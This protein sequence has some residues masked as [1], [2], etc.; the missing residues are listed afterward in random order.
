MKIKGASTMTIHQ[1]PEG[2]PM[3]HLVLPSK[4]S[5]VLLTELLS[6]I[7]DDFEV[8]SDG[9]VIC[10][11][12]SLPLVKL[13]PL[14]NKAGISEVR[15]SVPQLKLLERLKH[16]YAKFPPQR[17]RWVVS[18][19]GGK[20]ST[21][22]LMHVL[23]FSHSKGFQFS[24]VHEYTG[25]EIP[26]LSQ[27]TVRTLSWLSKQGV[28]VHILKPPANFFNV[29]LERG[30]G[31]PHW[32]RRWCCRIFKEK[33]AKA[34]LKSQSEVLNLIALR[35]DETRRVR[36]FIYYSHGVPT[37]LP[38]IDLNEP[39]VWELLEQ[40]PE[41]RSRLLQIYPSYRSNSGCWVCT[42]ARDD[43]V[44]RRLDPQLYRIKCIL[45][46]AR[47]EGLNQFVE[48]LQAAINERPDIFSG[49][50]WPQVLRDLKCRGKWCKICSM[51][52]WR[53]RGKLFV[54]G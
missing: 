54:E 21:A 9:K 22:L 47:C 18:Y 37:A 23:E 4:K 38:L 6:E 7:L 27:H 33:P 29:M 36:G 3:Y 51:R 10:I 41:V 20:D 12:R 13:E 48:Q 49:F 15:G 46:W 34:W 39:Q 19:S 42:V 53:E 44:L 28:E 35:G 2:E 45:A 11:P 8:H 30:Y 32:C 26:Q 31:F 1:C 50:H 14:F 24:V 43:L 25:M 16:L 17:F 40:F 5:R 52:T